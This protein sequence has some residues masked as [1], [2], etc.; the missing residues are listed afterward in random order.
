MNV[1][2]VFQEACA[3]VKSENKSAFVEVTEVCS[4]DDD[5]LRVRFALEVAIATIDDNADFFHTVLR[6]N[7]RY[8]VLIVPME[9]CLTIIADSFVKALPAM[10]AMYDG[11][12]EPASPV[13][14][15][16]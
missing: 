4:C 16:N 2:E 14:L 7:E 11:R 15:Q 12:P 3:R 10:V 9:F 13:S 5:V 8:F 1:L 6:C